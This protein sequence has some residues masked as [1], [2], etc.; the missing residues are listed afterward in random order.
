[1]NRRHFI[2][3]GLTLPIIMVPSMPFASFAT[4]VSPYAGRTLLLIELNEGNDGLNTVIPYADPLYK[5][6]RPKL[7]IPR[8]RILQVDERLGL[9]SALKP[10]MDHWQKKDMAIALGVK[11]PNPILS[12]FRSIDIWKQ[13]SLNNEYL[14]DGWI[15]QA[16]EE[17]RP[18]KSIP[19]DGIIL[20]RNSYGLLVG[21]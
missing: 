18:P 4:S 2:Q 5:K 11:Y 21:K 8:N 15:S 16:F 7:A 6:F 10:L 17:M 14:K 12:H 9:H 20:E 13:A 19:A 1:M 3:S